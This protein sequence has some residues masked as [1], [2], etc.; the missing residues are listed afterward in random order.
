MNTLVERIADKVTVT[1]SV[2]RRL[3]DRHPDGAILEVLPQ[4]VRQEQDCWYVAVRPDKEPPRLY[5]YCKALAEVEAE[6]LVQENILVVM[7]QIPA[8]R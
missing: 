8:G 3:Q 7:V 6:M 4:G 1:A 2:R 5:E